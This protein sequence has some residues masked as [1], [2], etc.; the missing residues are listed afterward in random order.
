MMKIGAQGR[1]DDAALYK[2]ITIVAAC[3]DSGFHNSCNKGNSRST[4]FRTPITSAGLHHCYV[5]VCAALDVRAFGDHYECH[6]KGRQE[7]IGASAS[8][9][10]SNKRRG[11][12]RNKH[13][14]EANRSHDPQDDGG[15]QRSRDIVSEKT[16]MI[17]HAV[18]D[19]HRASLE[20][21]A[22]RKDA[23]RWARALL[24]G[25]WIQADPA[26]ALANVP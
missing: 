8:K 2:Q 25:C 4:V 17:F 1:Y 10:C 11:G 14:N 21:Q 7:R 12:R 5:P 24:G 13:N 16:F 18:S 3:F 19:C 15:R 23:I 9:S 20:V 6:W 22:E 26:P